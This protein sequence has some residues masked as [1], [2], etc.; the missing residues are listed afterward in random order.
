MHDILYLCKNGPHEIFGRE[1]YKTLFAYG[2]WERVLSGLD[3]A[4][5]LEFKG[6]NY[7]TISE[8]LADNADHGA[9]WTTACMQYHDLDTILQ[10]TQ[11]ACLYKYVGQG[12]FVR[13]FALEW[14]R[15]ER[16]DLS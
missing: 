14:A 8:A 3:G 16:L 2:N 6:R 10:A 13:D 15:A 11:C 4:K 5:P 7:L 12:A 9:V 1:T